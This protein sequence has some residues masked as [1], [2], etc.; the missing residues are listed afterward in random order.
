MVAAT[1]GHVLTVEVWELDTVLRI[2]S[3]LT[4]GAVLLGLGFVYNR[5]ARQIKRLL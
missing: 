5:W 1:L 4:L 2:V 3:F